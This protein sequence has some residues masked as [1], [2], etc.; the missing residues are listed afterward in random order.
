MLA[1]CDKDVSRATQMSL[2]LSK[3][4]SVN[5]SVPNDYHLCAVSMFHP[6]VWCVERP[7]KKIF[8]THHMRIFDIQTSIGVMKKTENLTIA[9]GSLKCSLM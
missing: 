5:F 6:L 1:G 8:V 9:M 3:L 4:S 2:L 7:M